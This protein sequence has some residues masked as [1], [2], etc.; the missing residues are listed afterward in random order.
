M[1][2]SALADVQA[3]GQAPAPE[4]LVALEHLLPQRR[5]AVSDD[6]GCATDRRALF[7]ERTCKVRG[8]SQH[9]VHCASPG[10]RQAGTRRVPATS[11]YA[12][13]ALPWPCPHAP[14]RALGK[15]GTL[16][17]L[18]RGSREAHMGP[19]MHSSQAGKRAAVQGSMPRRCT[20]AHA[21]SRLSRT[22]QHDLPLDHT[23]C[24]MRGRTSKQASSSSF[25]APS[26]SSSLSASVG[27]SQ[28]PF[29]SARA[30]A[31][32]APGPSKGS[33]PCSLSGLRA[34]RALE[35]CIA[36]QHKPYHVLGP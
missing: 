24:R 2:L 32:S 18:F 7:R 10:N 3:L 17:A 1:Y 20:P 19:C 26:P 9:S 5:G 15:T 13:C 12:A 33:R 4:A 6:G 8:F 29:S 14:Q 28:S 36:A 11:S 30:L 35:A 16:A 21:R 27:V 25:A 22:P 23:P 31:A 34:E